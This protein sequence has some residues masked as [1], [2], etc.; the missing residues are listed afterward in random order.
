MLAFLFLTLKINHAT[1]NLS[2]GIKPAKPN[3]KGN[4]TIEAANFLNTSINKKIP[5]LG[6]GTL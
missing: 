3:R 6:G 5:P 4:G 1:I 2:K